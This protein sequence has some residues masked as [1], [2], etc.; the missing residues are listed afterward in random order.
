[1]WCLKMLK[2]FQQRKK[3]IRIIF[4]PNSMGLIYKGMKERVPIFSYLS[5]WFRSFSLIHFHS[6]TCSSAAFFIHLFTHPF[7]NLLNKYFLNVFHLPSIVIGAMLFSHSV[8]SKYLWPQGCSAPG[9][10]VFHCLREFAQTH[11]HWVV[12]LWILQ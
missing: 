5:Q 7:V 10:P 8:V 6:Y 2:C 1:M 12:V 11:V 3:R 9:F 4:L